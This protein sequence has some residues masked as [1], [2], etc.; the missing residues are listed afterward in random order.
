MLCGEGG[1]QWQRE[2]ETRAREGRGRGRERQ[3]EGERRKRWPVKRT[4]N[5]LTTAASLS[6]L[7]ASLCGYLDAVNEIGHA[8]KV[9]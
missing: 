8:L 6:I 9:D 4:V 3:R 2:R 5:K 1:G 7:S